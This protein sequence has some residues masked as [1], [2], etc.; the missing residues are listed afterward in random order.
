MRIKSWKV[1]ESQLGER[2]GAKRECLSEW[3]VRV[4][5][6]RIDDDAED[7]RDKEIMCDCFFPQCKVSPGSSPWRRRTQCEVRRD[8]FDK[9]HTVVAESDAIHMLCSVVSFKTA[10]RRAVQ[11]SSRILCDSCGVVSIRSPRL[12]VLRLRSVATQARAAH[13]RWML[14]A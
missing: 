6:D 13:L 3:A 11:T 4:K 10:R 2:V 9:E 5:L 7:E 12:V 14:D 8:S 1:R